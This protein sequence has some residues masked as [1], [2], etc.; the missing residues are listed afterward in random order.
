MS[1]IITTFFFFNVF[2]FLIVFS[3]YENQSDTPAPPAPP[4]PD[5]YFTIGKGGTGTNTIPINTNTSTNTPTQTQSAIKNN[6]A[7]GNFQR[8][9]FQQLVPDIDS[10]QNCQQSPKKRRVE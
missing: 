3:R 4:T 2:L 5:N 6:N 8:R 1:C 9:P 7:I 10:F